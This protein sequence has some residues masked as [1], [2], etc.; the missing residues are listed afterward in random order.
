MC[1][2]EGCRQER[3]PT[4]YRKREHCSRSVVPG[5]QGKFSRVGVTFSSWCYAGWHSKWEGS[6]NS[7]ARWNSESNLNATISTQTWK[8]SIRE[9]LALMLASGLFFFLKCNS[10]VNIMT[11]NTFQDH[12]RFSS[13]ALSPDLL[14]KCHH[15]LTTGCKDVPLIHTDS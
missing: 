9:Q 8:L 2:R 7:E 3:L 10:R 6:K 5:P 1:H 13:I 14:R 15:L 11:K 4:P 12:P